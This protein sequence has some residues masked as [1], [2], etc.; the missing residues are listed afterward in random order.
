MVA[1][2]AGAR[3]LFHLPSGKVCIIR[4]L[5]DGSSKTTIVIVNST[6]SVLV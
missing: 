1:I 6:Q 5:S 2:T 4:D 3:Q